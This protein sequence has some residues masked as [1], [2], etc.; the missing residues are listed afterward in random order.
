MHSL[1]QPFSSSSPAE[2]QSA[3][4]PQCSSPPFH[5][6][7]PPIPLA[8][9]PSWESLRERSS[10]C[11]IV[12]SAIVGGL[13]ARA[14]SATG[15]LGHLSRTNQATLCAAAGLLPARSHI[16]MLMNKLIKYDLDGQKR[17]IS[18]LM[19]AQRIYLLFAWAARYIAIYYP[20]YLRRLRVISI[21]FF[22]SKTKKNEVI[23]CVCVYIYQYF[24]WIEVLCWRKVYSIALCVLLGCSERLLAGFEMSLWKILYM[25]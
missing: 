13:S 11:I 2:T 15:R 17:A 22:Y 9:S 24:L 12:F 14:A 10:I 21:A 23:L 25:A 18:L 1:R 19:R 8:R 6:R 7:A 5:A 20:F 3:W 16:H 4:R